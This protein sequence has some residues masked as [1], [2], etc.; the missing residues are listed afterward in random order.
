MQIFGHTLQNPIGTSAGIDKHAEIPSPLLA[1]GPAIVEIGGVTPYPQDGNPKPRVFRLP[2]QRALINR[3]GLNSEGADSMAMRLRQRV[4]EY[5]YAM[6]FGIDEIAE[7]RVLDG[8]AMVPPGSLVDGKLLA[9][10]VAKNKFTA[11]NDIEAIKDDYVYCV[12][13]LARYADIIVVN[14]S[15]PNTPG[16]RDLQKSEPLTNIL[17]AVVSAAKTAD[18][19]TKPAV[20]VKVSPDE[21]S[22]EDI[23][24]I[25]DAVKNAAVDGVILGNTTKRRPDSIP[26]GYT[27]SNR[28]ATILLEQGGYSGP[29]LF[30]RTVN[31][32]KKYRKVLDE[33]LHRH[34]S[35]QFLPQ[36]APE[37]PQPPPQGLLSKDQSP[38][39]LA[40]STT[41]EKIEGTVQRDLNHLKPPTPEREAASSAQPLLRLPERNGPPSS[42]LYKPSSGD[43]P[44]LSNSSHIN[45]LPSPEQLHAD[46]PGSVPAQRSGVLST[47]TPA[48]SLPYPSK[49]S[50]TSASSMSTSSAREAIVIFATGG[51]ANGSQALEVL[52]AG[53]SVAMVYT[54][55]G[56][57]NPQSFSPLT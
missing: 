57:F 8:E 2:S 50:P 12:N 32:V 25:C 19:K 40:D 9:V 27:L 23:A 26:A 20:M 16:L 45:Q 13:A 6:G 44:T 35:D 21:D 54:A 7:Q 47:N 42:A 49:R 33:G 41:M 1:L 30:E 15:S 56:N 55:L 31:L 3:Y 39:S 22:D 18:R 4:R 28:E 51:I 5:A 11:D 48:S 53:A 43:P 38:N 37:K 24:G 34:T 29:Q 52:N 36:S 10:Q 17:K 46:P 14:V